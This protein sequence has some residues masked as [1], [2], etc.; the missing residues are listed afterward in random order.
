MAVWEGKSLI[1]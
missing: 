1:A